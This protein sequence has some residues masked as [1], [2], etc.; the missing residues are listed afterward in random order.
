VFRRVCSHSS[1]LIVFSRLT[2]DNR[3]KPPRSTIGLLQSNIAHLALT[4][5]SNT[6]CTALLHTTTPHYYSALSLQPL[7][8]RPTTDALRSFT[9]SSNAR[10][11]TTV[12][13]TDTQTEARQTSRIYGSNVCGSSIPSRG[14]LVHKLCRKN[15]LRQQQQ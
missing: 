14:I 15:C 4:L 13:R 1:H 11:G 12:Q 7:C 8:T 5:N 3:K 6:Y 2:C 10:Y 9:H